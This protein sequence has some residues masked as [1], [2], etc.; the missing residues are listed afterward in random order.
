MYSNLTQRD[1]CNLD[2]V[3]E[4]GA[5]IKHSPACLIPA[6]PRCFGYI[7]YGILAGRMEIVGIPLKTASGTAAKAAAVVL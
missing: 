1:F 3:K 4:I 2:L 7:E 6:S 5:I